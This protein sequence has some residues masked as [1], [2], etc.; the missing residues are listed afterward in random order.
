MKLQ[1][2]GA[3]LALFIIGATI[4]ARAA[5]EPSATNVPVLTTTPPVWRPSQPEG[6]G[7]VV[8]VASTNLI[9]PRIKF[10]SLDYDFGRVRSGTKVKHDFVFTNTGDAT[11]EI[12]GVT[13]GCGCTTV[14]EW[15]HQV[16]PGKTGVIPIQFDSSAYST[17]VRKTPHLTCNDKTQPLVT[18]LLHGT[19]FR[20]L[21][22]NPQYISLNISPDSD[23]ETNGVVHIVNNDDEPLTLEPPKS[24]QRFFAA[25]IRTNVPGKNYDL[26]IKTVPPLEPGENQGL[27]TLGTS[28]KSM[29]SINVFARALVLPLVAVTPA[30]IMLPAGPLKAKETATV[31]LRN[32]GSRPL[33][34]SEPSVNANGASATVDVSKPGQIFTAK[35]DFST[36]FEAPAGQ[37]LVLS[38]K[39]DNPRVPVIKVN[40]KQARTQ[41]GPVTSM[42]VT[43]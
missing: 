18:F 7:S 29:S 31:F 5:D 14:G 42:R 33:A 26:V 19:V 38:I 41:P 8:V 10:D 40:I 32:Q 28:S 25:E 17:A 37:Q 24:N 30:E 16:E 3:G 12:K 43:Q 27:I 35:V 20:S 6:S 9:G 4:G 13:P 23:E 34:L 11:L 1:F 39:T 36:G 2:L 15:T 21:D 22:V